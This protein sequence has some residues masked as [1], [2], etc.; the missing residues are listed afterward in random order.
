MARGGQ[1]AP[2]DELVRRHRPALLAYAGVL[3][4]AS[5]AEDVVQ[6]SLLKSYVALQQGAKP[7]MVRA[8]LFRI[9]R[10]TAIDE[11]RGT[12]HH[13]QLDENYDGVEQPPNALDRRERLAGLVLAIQDLP[14]AQREAIVQRE[15]EGKG[16]E[17]IGRALRVSPGSVRQLIYRARHALR[18]AAGSIIPIA[19]IRAASTPGAGEAVS[20]LGA[21]GALK[22]GLATIVATGTIVATS[23]VDR[24][25][26]PGTAQ[27]EQLATPRPN[28]GVTGSEADGSRVRGDDRGGDD[29]RHDSGS[30]RDGSSGKGGEGSDGS[31]TSGMSGDSGHGGFSDEG[32]GSNSGPG[33][34]SSGESGSGGSDLSGGNG[35]T[36][37]EDS[38]SGG[39]GNVL[40]EVD[41]G[42]SG[43]SG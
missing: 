2:F 37:G 21:A 33:S 31:G 43:T 14:D 3:A 40:L 12:R 27:A 34:G 38:G 5:R 11:Q 39:D 25:A 30:S 4:P 10:N 6:D 35:G 1:Q 20:G 17:E 15:I 26:D 18:E 32:E 8:W 22:L 19:V 29:T 16:H 9:V 23:S 24:G 36:S 42:T 13:E 28:A 41:G 7:E